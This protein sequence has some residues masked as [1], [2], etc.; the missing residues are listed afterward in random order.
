MTITN[1]TTLKAA[2]SDTLA[3]ADLEDEVDGFI[4]QAEARFNRR[5]RARDMEASTTLALNAD[6]EATLPSDFLEFRSLSCATTPKSWPQIVDVDSPDFLFRFR[7]NANPQYVGI[8]AT[9]IVVRP[10]ANVSADLY[11]Y[12]RIPALTSGAPTNWLVTDA[13]DIY[14]YGA[15]LEAAIYIRD[16]ERITLYAENLAAAIEE[17]TNQ[18]RM[19]RTSKP[20]DAPHA[21]GYRRLESGGPQVMG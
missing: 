20:A 16:Q 12:Q 21:P 15:C 11:Y 10:A 6:G 18:R 17:L 5:I 2:V 1:Y 14:L 13:P 3:R 19:D 8:M 9:T 7:P 4:S